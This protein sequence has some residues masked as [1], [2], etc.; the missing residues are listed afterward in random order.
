MALKPP[1]PT[2]GGGTAVVVISELIIVRC[3]IFR[4]S[5]NRFCLWMQN[6]GRTYGMT[7]GTGTV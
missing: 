5:A 1:H 4:L 2:G 6:D 7:I 3:S